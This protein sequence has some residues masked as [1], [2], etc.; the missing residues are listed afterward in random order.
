MNKIIIMNYPNKINFKRLLK[1]L[2][3]ILLIDK[4]Q[5]IKE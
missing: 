4:F 5:L 2:K 3:A 1:I